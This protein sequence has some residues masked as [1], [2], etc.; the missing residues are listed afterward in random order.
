MGRPAVDLPMHW[1]FHGTF[2]LS[3]YLLLLQVT[4]L[5]L[6][7][8]LGLIC[9]IES[10]LSKFLQ[11]LCVGLTLTA[12]VHELVYLARIILLPQLQ[13]LDLLEL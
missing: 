1:L 10:L 7:I 3:A 4:S 11:P 8:I 9:Q 5:N 6:S 2:V 13:G 12:L